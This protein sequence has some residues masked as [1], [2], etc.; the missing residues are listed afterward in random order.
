[1]VSVLN[2]SP[3]FGEAFWRQRTP[4]ILVEAVDNAREAGDKAAVKLGLAGLCNLVASV[5]KVLT[6]EFFESTKIVRVILA[7]L[8]AKKF[9]TILPETMRCIG[10]CLNSS[11]PVPTADA[12][13]LINKADL[14]TDALVKVFQSKDDNVIEV[15]VWTFQPLAEYLVQSSSHLPH[16]EFPWEI[17][18]V[19]SGIIDQVIDFATKAEHPDAFTYAMQILTHFAWVY[20]PLIIK[21]EGHKLGIQCLNKHDK[22]APET[23]IVGVRIYYYFF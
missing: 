15:G 18:L 23:F 5:A 13:R 14:L 7:I 22:N 12:I 11:Q 2:N 21:A 9:D 16:H 4:Y 10:N 20:S 6:E 8:K 17:K 19:K 3:R 1:L